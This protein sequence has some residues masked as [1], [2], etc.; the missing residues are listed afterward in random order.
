MLA[1]L[2]AHHFLHVSRI[3]VNACLFFRYF[4]SFHISSFG[5][6]VL[7]SVLF[8]R[9]RTVA[10]LRCSLNLKVAFRGRL[11]GFHCT[12]T[13]GVGWVDSPPS[14]LLLRLCRSCP[15]KVYFSATCPSPGRVTVPSAIDLPRSHIAAIVEGKQEDF[16]FAG[17]ITKLRYTKCFS[18]CTVGCQFPL[19]NE[20]SGLYKAFTLGHILVSCIHFTVL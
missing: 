5:T 18:E 9:F 3:R 16:S 19:S 8:R 11:R 20:N 1:L 17:N 4:V 14:H 6:K 12:S 10:A 2:G 13:E 15:Q 7:T